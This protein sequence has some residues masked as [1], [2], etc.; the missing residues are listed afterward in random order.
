MTDNDEQFEVELDGFPVSSNAG[1]EHVRDRV[2]ILASEFAERR[3][4]DENPSIDE[5]VEKYP[6]LAGQI[7]ELFPVVAAMEHLKSEREMA[8]LQ[9]RVPD[10]MNLERLG[11]C[12][13]IRELARGGMGIV[14][15][16]EQDVTH[17]RVAVKLL[18][19]QSVDV[20]R[21]RDRFIREAQT[22]A[23]LRHGNIVPFLGF[24]EHQGFSYYVMPFI[25]GVG[26]DWIVSRLRESDGIAYAEEIVSLRSASTRSA[27]TG[28]TAEVN[29]AADNKSAV[30]EANPVAEADSIANV[31]H[32]DPSIQRHRS[33]RRNSWR[34]F[35]V[36]ALQVANALRYAHRKG[37]LHNDIKPA[38]LLLDADGRVWIT[39][40]GLA[41]PLD[42]AAADVD[43]NISGTL[44][45]M[46]PE[47]F[48]G[49]GDE[50]SDLYSLGL[51]L[52]ELITLEPAW[53]ESDRRLLIQNIMESQPSPP[54][55]TDPN[56]PA[57]LEKI[58]L[59]AIATE[60]G[61][62]YQTAGEIAEDLLRFLNGKP[63]RTAKPSVIRRF[64]RWCWSRIWS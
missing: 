5:Y 28:D 35:A 1:E 38:N 42:Q 62:R 7:L 24:G 18:P 4:N 10:A 29:S 25:E 57:D 8:G 6:E 33:L 49:H 46:A 27:S 32:P 9:K 40:F 26:L 3:R 20:P 2:E 60:P 51:T 21:W 64:V 52:Y 53:Q 43:G 23:K 17:R 44:R 19:W 50:R 36:I 34:K 55:F 39:D 31:D 30:R 11:D 56:L 22:V 58:V 45:Y 54:R 13:I 61:D 37:V 63:V 15:E 41:Q 47:R 48:Q 12:R 16:A 14:F 59:K